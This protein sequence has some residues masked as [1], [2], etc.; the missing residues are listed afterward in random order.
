MRL[1]GYEHQDDEETSRR[2][3]YYCF[4]YLLW[5]VSTACQRWPGR[6]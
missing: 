2:G 1:V 4:Y 5:R 3:V 6:T